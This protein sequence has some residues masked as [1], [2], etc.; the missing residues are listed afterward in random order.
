MRTAKA[1]DRWGGHWV[2]TAK[3]AEDVVPEATAS[4]LILA[5][6]DAAPLEQVEASIERCLLGPGSSRNRVSGKPSRRGWRTSL[7][8]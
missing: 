1:A 3:A 6:L 8:L 7:R 4:P 2:R 5:R